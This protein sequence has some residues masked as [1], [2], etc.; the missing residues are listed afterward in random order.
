MEIEGTI[1]VVIIVIVVVKQ[2]VELREY[3]SY[4]NSWSLE[5]PREFLR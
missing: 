3:L 4:F 5:C 2:L 1:D